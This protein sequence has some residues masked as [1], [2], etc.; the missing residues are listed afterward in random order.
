MTHSL[1]EAFVTAGV[2]PNP[3]AKAPPG[4]DAKVGD[5]ISYVKWGVLLVIIM[6]GF[7]GAGA[8]AGGR[9]FSHHGSSKTGQGM[10]VAAVMAAVLY[11]G[12]YAFLT[13]VTG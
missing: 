3:G 1:I 9:V 10:L 4:V 6:V 5:I 8:V 2:V 12:I 11:A 13:S 7:I